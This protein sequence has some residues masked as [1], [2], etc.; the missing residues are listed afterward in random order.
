MGDVLLVGINSDA[1]VKRLKGPRRPVIG[2]TDRAAMLAALDCVAYVVIFDEDTPHTML[3]AIQPDVLVKGGTY[4]PHE[5]V[6]HEVVA[7]YGGKVRVTGVVEGISTTAILKSLH[8][9]EEPAVAGKIAGTIVAGSPN[10][11]DS[12]SVTHR[13][14]AG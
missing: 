2:E 3:H 5:V 13:R 8:H 12:S 6:G 14:R 11:E 9:D 10:V 7:S 4:A 1:S